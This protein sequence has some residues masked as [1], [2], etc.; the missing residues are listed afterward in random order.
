MTLTGRDID[1]RPAA[2]S[3]AALASVELE[4]LDCVFGEEIIL[5][6]VRQLLARSNVLE[7][8][9]PDVLAFDPRNTVRVA[10]M[11]DEPR[12]VPAHRRID[13]GA[14]VENEEEGVVP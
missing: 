2:L 12:D 5:V 8:V 7:G 4:I 9:D 6:V 3:A 13:T 14:A 10:G 1:D 11:V